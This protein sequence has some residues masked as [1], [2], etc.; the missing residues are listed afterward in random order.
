MSDKQNVI[1]FP[2][3]HVI[4]KRATEELAQIKKLAAKKQAAVVDGICKEVADSIYEVL[5]ELEYTSDDIEFFKDFTYTMEAF[6][7]MLLRA[8]YIKH[9]IQEEADKLTIKTKPKK[10]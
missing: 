5:T 3:E 2:I 9:P 4:Q 6:R 7:S 10:D 1:K 8:S